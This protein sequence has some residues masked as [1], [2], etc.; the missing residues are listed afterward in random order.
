MNVLFIEYVLVPV[1]VQATHPDVD[2]TNVKIVHVCIPYCSCLRSDCITSRA[3]TATGRPRSAQGFD[4]RGRERRSR[5]A[6]ALVRVVVVNSDCSRYD[7]VRRLL[8]HACSATLGAQ[9]KTARFYRLHSCALGAGC[10]RLRIYASTDR[11][12]HTNCP[13]PEGG[14]RRRCNVHV[15]PILRSARCPHSLPACQGTG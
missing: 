7:G 12:L 13:G 14:A 1:V 4:S 15:P 11:L 8:W 2:Y 5:R 3:S 10:V 9:R 6:R